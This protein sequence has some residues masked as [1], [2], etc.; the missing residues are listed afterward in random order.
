MYSSYKCSI[1][2]QCNKM[3]PHQVLHLF[4]LGADTLDIMK[5]NEHSLLK[6]APTKRKEKLTLTSIIK[7]IL[8]NLLR[9]MNSTFNSARESLKGREAEHTR[10][11]YQYYSSPPLGN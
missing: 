7:K 5:E 8:I 10:V 4:F 11:T 2:L 9:T 3:F 1:T 6:P